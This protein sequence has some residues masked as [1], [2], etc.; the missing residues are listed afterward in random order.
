V[1]AAAYLFL[2]KG[3]ERENGGGPRKNG[4]RKQETNINKTNNINNKGK[5]A[6]APLYI[7]TNAHRKKNT[8]TSI[9]VRA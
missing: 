3:G 7:C 8:S 4:G 5:G 6:C 9:N 2:S 1:Q